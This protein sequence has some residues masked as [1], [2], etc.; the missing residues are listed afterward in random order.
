M[1]KQMITTMDIASHHPKG[2]RCSTDAEYSKVGNKIFK[3]FNDANIMDISKEDIKDMAIKL[4]LYFEDVVSDLGIWRS[5]TDWNKAHYGKYIPFY[6]YDEEYYFQDQPQIEDI[7]LILWLSFSEVSNGIS[8]PYSKAT[9]ILSKA[10]FDVM[11]EEFENTPINEEF[12]SYL[13]KAEFANDFIAQRDVLKWLYFSCYLTHTQKCEGVFMNEIRSWTERIN[14]EMG[15]YGAECCV[16]YN[17]EIGP[18]NLHTPQWLAMI[19]RANQNDRAAKVI[20]E[21][22]YREI[23]MYKIEEIND[24]HVVFRAPNDE[25]LT[26][27]LYALN[28]SD[29]SE[30]QEKFALCSLVKYDG[31]WQLNGFFTTLASQK[32]F[33]EFVEHAKRKQMEMTPNYKHLMKLS[34]G[35]PLFYMKNRAEFI[36]FAIKEMKVP[37]KMVMESFNSA[38]E[39]YDASS[40]ITFF[41]KSEKGAQCLA[42]GVAGS[43]KDERNPYYDKAYAQKYALS[44]AFQM[45]VEICDYL[46][47]HHML[48][49]ASFVTYKDDNIDGNKLLLENIE[50]VNRAIRGIH[51]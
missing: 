46:I 6:D 44:D 8:Y 33:D 31:A 23:T 2:M 28:Y 29:T 19:L 14:E 5:F 41:I 11:E 1:I 12:K 51:L 7:Q 42:I 49:D 22:E 4:T 47:S 50:F 45:P 30:L 34:G 25:T 37:K 10:A 27:T 32:A 26:I 43:I 39:K 24:D 9:I 16:T 38:D 35:S 36:A 48:P 17:L 40:N 20:E 21:Q 15:V 3:K 13:E 18:L